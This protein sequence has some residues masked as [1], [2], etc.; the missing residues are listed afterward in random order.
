MVYLF[1]YGT[2]MR[3]QCNHYI[4]DCCVFIGRG[5]TKEKYSLH[6]K[7]NIPFMH[8][9]EGIS[10]I[11]GEIYMVTSDIMKDIDKLECNGDWYTR[12]QR[13]VICENNQTEYICWMYF[14]N[15][16]IGIVI[17]GDYKRYL[18]NVN[19]QTAK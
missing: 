10:E 19:N 18:A 4:I 7:G 6:M 14:C 16:E 13:Q 8:D 1:V 11:Y 15:E 9:D 2:L 12:K 3:N 17:D 5:Y